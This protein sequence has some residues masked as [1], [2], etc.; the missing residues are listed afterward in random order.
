M[1]DVETIWIPGKPVPFG[2]PVG[3]AV[4]RYH[5]PA[6]YAVWKEA[7]GYKIKAD[8]TMSFDGPVSVMVGVWADGVSLMVGETPKDAR[9]EGVRGDLDNYVKAVL[10]A[11]QDGG[12]ISDDRM[13]HSIV[14]QFLPSSS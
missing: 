10:D 12:L 11:A 14:A 13:V 1:A 4:G 8:K 5:N 3:G 9:P 6:N 2:R 7:A